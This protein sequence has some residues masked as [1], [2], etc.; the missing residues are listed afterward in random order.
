MFSTTTPI[1]TTEKTPLVGY[2]VSE[3][4]ESPQVDGIVI[5]EKRPQRTT[6]IGVDWYA[7]GDE[8]FKVTCMRRLGHHYVLS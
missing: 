2:V 5:V 4:M 1:S 3:E 8:V 6:L 7:A